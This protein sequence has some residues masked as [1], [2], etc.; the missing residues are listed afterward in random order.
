MAGWAS[1]TAYVTLEDVRVPV[2]NLIGEENSGFKYIMTNL[3]VILYKYWPLNN[4]FFASNH[5]RWSLIIQ[6]NRFS[7]V[8][9][10]EALKYAHKRYTF[11]KRL[12]DHPVIRMK[13]ANMT[14]HIEGT[15]SW[16]ENVTYQLVQ[17]PP[18]QAL[19]QLGGP[20][21]LLKLQATQTFEFCVREAQQI[22]GGLGYTRGG[23]GEKV[24][25]LS[26]EVRAVRL[27]F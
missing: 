12:I 6:A 1:G 20:I 5:E 18:K 25:R 13:I 19:S 7:R 14:R 8:C 3:Y 26:R 27:P 22:F 11:G 2:A 17:Q 15:Q 21:A 16:L 24:E 9:L 4:G 10:E 23:Q